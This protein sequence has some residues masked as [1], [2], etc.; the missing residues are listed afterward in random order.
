M[1][2]DRVTDW[3]AALEERQ[4]KTVTFPEMRRAVQAISTSYVERRDRLARNVTWGAGKRAAFAFYYGS[5]HFLTIR[6]LVRALELRTA[7]VGRII[8]L[9]CGTGVASAACALELATPPTVLALDKDSFAVSE[10]R[11]T[12]QF[13]GIAATVRV[14]NI[15]SRPAASRGDLILAAF[16][17]NEVTEQD[18]QILL[19]TLVRDAAQG[20]TVLVVEPIARR[21]APWWGAW[22]K[23]VQ[24][25]GGR[26]DE[27]RFKVELPERI[28]LM[29]KAAGLRHHELTCRSLWLP[30]Q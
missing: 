10:A 2:A 17:V 30:V 8:D 28:A 12:Y 20:S 15:L 14:G 26:S 3:L 13:F 11:W 9:G 21:A 19:R 7:Q 5:L 18:R 27:W 22:E 24:E 23:V 16:S 29:D 4:L 25:A 1:S 6:E